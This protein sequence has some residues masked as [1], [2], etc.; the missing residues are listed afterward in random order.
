MRTNEGT[1]PQKKNKYLTAT[2]S[3]TDANYRNKE[4]GFK[5][6]QDKM[7]RFVH[8]TKIIR[9]SKCT[10]ITFSAFTARKIN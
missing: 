6:S 8:M 9:L 10:K 3:S 5:T 1:S 4:T 2:V 7:F